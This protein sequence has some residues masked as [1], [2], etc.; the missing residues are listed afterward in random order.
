MSI[1]ALVF[2]QRGDEMRLEGYVPTLKRLLKISYPIVLGQVSIVLMGIT[3]NMMVGQTGS[4][5]LAA[6]SI[7]NSTFFLLFTLGIG[8]VS[9]LAPL[10]ATAKGADTTSIVKDYFHMGLV[11]ALIAG[12][13]FGIIFG[14]FAGGISWLEQPPEVNTLAI[15]YFRIIGSSALPLAIFMA[16]KGVSDGLGRTIQ[17]FWITL[18]GLVVNILLN[19]TLIFGKFGFPAMG[20]NGAGW[21]TLIARWL[22]AIL[23]LWQLVRPHGGI[24]LPLFPFSL[25]RLVFI[26]IGRMGLGAGLQYFFETSAFVFAA[27]IIGWMG[28]EKLAAHQIAMGLASMTYMFSLGISIAGSIMVGEAKGSN[29]YPALVRAGRVCFAVTAVFTFFFASCF[30]LLNNW[31]PLLYVNPAEHEVIMI[32]SELLLICSIFQLSDGTQVVAQG[33]LRGLGDIKI[34]T[35]ITLVVY[36][37]IG[38]PWAY[39]LGYRSGWGVKGV[40]IGFAI[41][42]SASA[43]LQC[44]R[45]L[46]LVKQKSKY[47]ATPQNNVLPTMAAPVS[48]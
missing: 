39:F 46:S 33:L 30:I 42:L 24:S 7:V 4:V 18:I 23:I 11:W 34:P 47:V 45:Y 43:I 3:D 40:W 1:F 6:A 37:G 16:A 10:T 38:L 35:I 27:Y 32:A 14:V 9:V 31:L 2:L 48:A 20:L 13:G 15:P 41:G 12:G 19:W 5:A 28:A 8:I 25:N 29:N 26:K 36:V 44:W 22:M 21:A 17:G